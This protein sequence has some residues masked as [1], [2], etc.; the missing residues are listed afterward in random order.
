MRLLL[1]N[2]MKDTE[3]LLHA[4][5][6]NIDKFPTSAKV[7]NVGLGESNLLNIAGG[8]ASEN[9]IVYIYGVAGFIIHRLEQ[10]KFSC[11]DFGATI[12]KIIICNAGRIGYEKM[13]DGHK[14]EDD[15]AICKMLNIDFY[16]PDTLKG[17]RS[18]LN[19]IDTY[20]NGIYY[21]NLGKDFER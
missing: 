4:D 6:F 11:R 3:Y 20:Q 12:G 9:N 15:Q 17:F 5:M 16:K 8:I 14:L 19:E 2:Y 10:L 21:I 7:I 13:G 18:I 1:A